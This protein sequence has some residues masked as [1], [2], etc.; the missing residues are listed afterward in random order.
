MPRLSKIVLAL[1]IFFLLYVFRLQIVVPVFY[2][3]L[4][5]VLYIVFFFWAKAKK[6]DQTY[7]NWDYVLNTPQGMVKFLV[8]GSL[9]W[10]AVLYPMIRQMFVKTKETDTEEKV[11]LFSWL[12]YLINPLDWH[13]TWFNKFYQ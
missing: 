7:P 8:T 5:F 2:V 6:L 1:L 12:T 4:G 3:V 13:K 11:L 9:I 10:F